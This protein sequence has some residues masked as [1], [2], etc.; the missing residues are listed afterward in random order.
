MY[1]LDWDDMT[2][3]FYHLFKDKKKMAKLLKGY[4]KYKKVDYELFQKNISQVKIND[5][6]K[7]AKIIGKVKILK[8]K[9]IKYN[10]ITNTE[11]F[12]SNKIKHQDFYDLI[13]NL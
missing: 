5:E 6:I 11:Y 13:N 4:S 9:N 2:I 8:K 1:F 7:D 12:Y 3:P 10:I